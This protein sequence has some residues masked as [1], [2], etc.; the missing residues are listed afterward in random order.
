MVKC[1]NFSKEEAKNKKKYCKYRERK[2]IL[3]GELGR[4][5]EMIC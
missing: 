2:S 5:Y 3:V 1:D 4:L